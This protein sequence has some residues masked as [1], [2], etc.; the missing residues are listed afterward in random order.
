MKEKTTNNLEL[1]LSLIPIL[2]T[3]ILFNKYII[4][5]QDVDD[6]QIWHWF[7]L[8]QWAAIYFSIAYLSEKYIFILGFAFTYPFL[9]DSILYLSLGHPIDYAGANGFGAD[10]SLTFPVKILLFV[11]GVLLITISWV[12]EK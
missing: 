2:V 1:L 10:Y 8:L 11:I 12:K 3:T 4:L 7:Q 5:T 9:Y 6:N